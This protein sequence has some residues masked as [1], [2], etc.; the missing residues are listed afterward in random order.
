[1][2]LLKTARFTKARELDH[3]HF[4]VGHKT[5]KGEEIN[6]KMQSV[7]RALRT[8]WQCGIPNSQLL[9]LNS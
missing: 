7:G 2:L 8:T 9:I 6:L 1:L 5:N 4:L 3:L